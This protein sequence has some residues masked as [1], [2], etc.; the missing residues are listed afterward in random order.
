MIKIVSVAI[1]CAIII[2]Y[3]KNINSELTILAEIMSVIIVIYLG[4][5][6]L[7]NTFS[8]INKLV[9]ASKLDKELYVIILKVVG[10]GYLIEFSA[11]IVEDFGIKSLADKLIL[12]GKVIILG[13]S[14]PIIYAVFNLVTGLFL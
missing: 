1:I 5:G 13:M 14:M 4:L 9:V 6:Y 11:S 8:I 2:L 10:I 7:E 3:L 12:V